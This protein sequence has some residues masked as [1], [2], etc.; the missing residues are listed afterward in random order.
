M[1]AQRKLR[2]YRGPG[3][4]RTGYDGGKPLTAIMPKHLTCQWIDGHGAE[5]HFSCAQPTKEGSSYCS[6]HHERVYSRHIPGWLKIKR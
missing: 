4:P 3:R 1:T 2:E 6:E 5:K